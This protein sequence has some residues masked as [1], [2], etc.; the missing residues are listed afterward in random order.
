ME[1]QGK[2]IKDLDLYTAAPLEGHWPQFGLV[3]GGGGL[4]A[5]SQRMIYLGSAN[6]HDTLIYACEAFI[7][8]GGGFPLHIQIDPVFELP[9]TGSAI[10]VHITTPAGSASRAEPASARVRTASDQV[11]DIKAAFGLSVSQLADVVRV[12]RPTIY[13]WF[14]SDKGPNTLRGAHRDRLSILCRLAEEWNARST[15]PPGR[16]LSAMVVGGASLLQLLSAETLDDVAIYKAFDALA[17]RVRGGSEAGKSS[18]GDD[19]RKKGFAE[20][21]PSRR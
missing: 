9:P 1:L 17:E 7:G 11:T 18:F 15:T 12:K 5:K 6:L 13:A 3:Q 10:R 21:P 4:E 19:M 2:L 16:F 14:S 20:V 8:T